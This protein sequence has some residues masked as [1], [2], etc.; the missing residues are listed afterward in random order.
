MQIGNDLVFIYKH[1]MCLSISSG[2][3]ISLFVPHVSLISKPHILATSAFPE[4][5]AKTLALKL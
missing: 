1:N 4:R 3:L 5:E 2:K